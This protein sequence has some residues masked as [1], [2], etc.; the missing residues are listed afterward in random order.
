MEESAI[1]SH[2][3]EF[4][5]AH[6]CLVSLVIV[7]RERVCHSLCPENTAN[8]TPREPT[9]TFISRV[10]ETY[11]VLLYDLGKGKEKRDE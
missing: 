1:C 11:F 9:Q 5:D 10:K 3:R 8:I 7:S 2:K 6:D 4:T